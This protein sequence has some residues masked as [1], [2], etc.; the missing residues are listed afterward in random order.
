MNK[1]LLALLFFGVFMGAMDLAILGPALHSIQNT[2]HVT[3]RQ[4]IWIINSYVLFNLISTPL[5]SKLSD[6]RGRRIIYIYSILIFAIGSLV[7]IFST[8]FYLVILGRSIQGFG[9][10]GLFPVASSVIGDTFPKDKQG[11]ALGLLSAVYGLAFLIGPVI[12]GLLLLLSWRWVFVINLPLAVALIIGSLKLLPSKHIE[13]ESSFDW[14][15]T[16][17]LVSCLALFAFSLNRIN[18]KDFI[19]SL[20]SFKVLPFLM[21]SFLIFPFFIYHQK[22]VSNPI[23]NIQ[24]FRSKQLVIV[25]LL[26]LGAGLGEAGMIF[27]PGFAK[28][29]FGLS[30]SNA[31][32]SLVPML[33]ALLIGAVIAGRLIDI[34]GP[35]YILL[36]GTVIFTIG[37]LGLWKASGKLN[38]FYVSE[39]ILGLGFSSIIGAPIRYV[40]N[41]E[42]VE[43][44]RASGQGVLT[45]SMSVGLLMSASLMGALIASLGGGTSGYKG[46]YFSLALVSALMIFASLGLKRK[47][48]R[49]KPS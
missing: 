40:V 34:M 21:T 2:F 29:A 16:I 17:L 5:L 1:R 33:I 15:G 42:T 45:I 36:F 13:K 18:T 8:G 3:H 47:I 6:L 26:A 43:G 12:G 14:V 28:E 31:S 30:N 24:L 48:K 19:A 38:G 9:S 22:K 46:A 10:G 41:R 23:I 35:K 7:V 27:I 20:I 11:S 39:A 32:F 4:I 37:L 49:G 44:N 25:Y